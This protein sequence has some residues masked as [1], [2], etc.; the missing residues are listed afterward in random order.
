MKPPSIRRMKGEHTADCKHPSRRLH[1]HTH[2]HIF[3]G[4]AG[5][6]TLRSHKHTCSHANDDEVEGHPH[7]AVNDS[8]Q[9]FI[10]TQ[11][12]CRWKEVVVE[13][14]EDG[15]VEGMDDNLWGSKKCFAAVKHA[16]LT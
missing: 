9:S 14:V 2:T 10:H 11:N 3:G 15:V 5:L 4:H 1:T 6:Y 16:R 7:L 8:T 12:N 13:G